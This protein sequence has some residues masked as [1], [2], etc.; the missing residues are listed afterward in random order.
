VGIDD[1]EMLLSAKMPSA[2]S[3]AP[4]GDVLVAAQ[5]TVLSALF[6]ETKVVFIVGWA[7]S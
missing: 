3:N 4:F 1:F 6:V 5:T 2:I 7:N